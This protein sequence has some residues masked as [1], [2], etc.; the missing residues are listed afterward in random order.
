M[1]ESE[2]CVREGRWERGHGWGL[3]TKETDKQIHMI[4]SHTA[5]AI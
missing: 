2:E 4:F 1:G 5:L 3:G